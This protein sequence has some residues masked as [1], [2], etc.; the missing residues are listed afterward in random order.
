MISSLP[1]YDYDELQAET[2]AFWGAIAARLGVR[3]QLDRDPDHTAAWRR[4]D[5]LFSQT[6]GYPFTHDFKEKLRLVATPHYVVDGCDGPYYQSMVFAR[7]ARPLESFAGACAAVN[8]ADSMS[9]MLALKLIFAP[10]AKDGVFFSQAIETG[11]HTRSMIAVRDG[12]ADICAIDAVCT[13][14]ARRYRPDLIEGLVE[15][16]RSPMVPSLPFVTAGTASDAQVARLRDALAA[17]FADP[18]LAEVRDRLF[19]AGL[20]F[21]DASDYDRIPALE[22]GMERAGGLRLL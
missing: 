1:M 12:L 3:I 4:P 21:L 8:N 5:L 13:A 2:G 20:S 11:G 22:R 16:A 14:F 10:L 7:E 17:V 18:S 9:G 6:C 19:L 15:I